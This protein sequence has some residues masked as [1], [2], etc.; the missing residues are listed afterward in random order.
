MQR[1]TLTQSG[2]QLGGLPRRPQAQV[3]R[4]QAA[5]VRADGAAPNLLTI[6]VD[7]RKSKIFVDLRYFVQ[8]CAL[9]FGERAPLR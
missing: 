4:R 8:N 2:G 3:G 6:R 9:I 5:G 7:W 1:R